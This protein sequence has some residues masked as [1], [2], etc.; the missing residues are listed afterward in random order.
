MLGEWRSWIERMI[1]E[2]AGPLRKSRSLSLFGADSPTQLTHR[3]VP[4]GANHPPIPV[5]VIADVDCE[6]M[7]KVWHPHSSVVC[8]VESENI[9]TIYKSAAMLSSRRPP[10]AGMMP[11]LTRHA[12]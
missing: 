12:F 9:C 6:R 3:I 8:D 7:V 4:N 1:A 10:F 2:T 11:D 5:V